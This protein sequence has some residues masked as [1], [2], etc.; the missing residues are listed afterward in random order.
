MPQPNKTTWPILQ[1]N[2]NSEPLT[3]NKEFLLKLFELQLD[4]A[5]YHFDILD[6]SVSFRRQHDPLM[7]VEKFSSLLQRKMEVILQVGSP[8]CDEI[9]YGIRLQATG[10]NFERFVFVD[11]SLTARNFEQ[12][13][14]TFREVF[15]R[16]IGEDL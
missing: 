15:K 6:C 16:E 3:R 7:T 2:L 8:C 10:E 11:M 13:N 1:L 14:A 12:V 5:E 4:N 9:R